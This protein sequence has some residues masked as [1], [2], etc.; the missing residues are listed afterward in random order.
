MS[1]S[2]IWSPETL[3]ER[4]LQRLRIDA[5][6]CADGHNLRAR[7]ASAPL[8]LQRD[9]HAFANDLQYRAPRRGIGSVDHAFGPV[10]VH[11]QTGRRFPQRFQ[12]KGLLR[13]LAP[14]AEGL[15]VIVPVAMNPRT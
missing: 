3:L 9:I 7:R 2:P 11:R 15:R 6:K 5:A 12:G 14:R 4:F 13:L 1:L 10:D 8:V